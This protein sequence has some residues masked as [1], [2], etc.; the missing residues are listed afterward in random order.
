[1]SQN[2]RPEIINPEKVKNLRRIAFLLDNSIPIPGTKYRI[3]LDPILGLLGIVGGTG[4]IIGG[5]FGSYIVFQAAII[6]LPQKIIWQMIGNILVDSLVGF[7][8][9][10]GDIFDLTWKANARNIALLNEYLNIA[11]AKS[12][13]NPLFV[14][15]ITLVL[16]MIIL[17]FAFLTITIIRAIFQF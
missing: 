13:N 10:L 11:P 16:A 1:M 4:D 2:N 3:G 9:G 15:I 14:I 17:V 8:P 12:N 6:G 5:A 7:I